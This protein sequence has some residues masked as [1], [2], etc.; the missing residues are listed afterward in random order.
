MITVYELALSR[1]CVDP[2][3]G[4]VNLSLSSSQLTVGGP[5]DTLV[6]L[7]SPP[8]GLTLYAVNVYIVQT[9]E[10]TSTIDPRKTHKLVRPNAYIIQAGDK[11]PY[12]NVG[13]VERMRKSGVL[14]ENTEGGQ[15]EWLLERIARMV[16]QLSGVRT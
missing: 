6:H 1:T 11:G 8:P 2:S 3:L 7:V 9:V 10:V 13:A 5:L 15:G 16:S 4:L 12:D 14:W